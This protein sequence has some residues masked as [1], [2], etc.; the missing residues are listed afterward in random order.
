MWSALQLTILL[1]VD[2]EL[3]VGDKAPDDEHVLNPEAAAAEEEEVDVLDSDDGG[4]AVQDL[5]SRA[6][7]GGKEMGA[8]W[9]EMVENE[10]AVE[11]E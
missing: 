7:E 5:E 11:K 3:A 6:P 10:E 2:R 4:T 8:S 1:G 9:A